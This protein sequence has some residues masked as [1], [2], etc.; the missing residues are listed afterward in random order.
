M[1]KIQHEFMI[2]PFC[3]ARGIHK[4][5]LLSLSKLLSEFSYLYEKSLGNVFRYDINYDLGENNMI[6][7]FQNDFKITLKS[8]DLDCVSSIVLTMYLDKLDNQDLYYKQPSLKFK[9][10]QGK[11]TKTIEDN[12]DVLNHV[13]VYS[14]KGKQRNLND[15]VV[16]LVEHFVSNTIDED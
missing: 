15:V 9:F 2:K 8:Q 11:L 14:E 1:K 10:K 5:E 6:F 13:F 7:E 16:K 12:I 3:I 4:D